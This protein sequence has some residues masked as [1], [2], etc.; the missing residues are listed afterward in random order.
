MTDAIIRVWSRSLK[1]H[2]RERIARDTPRYLAGSNRLCRM[3]AED[4][5]S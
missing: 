4:F 5:V 3:V 2:D 1:K